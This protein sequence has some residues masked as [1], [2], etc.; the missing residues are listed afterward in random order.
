MLL[1]YEK[2]GHNFA[3]VMTTELSWHVQI[4]DLIESLESW[5]VQREFMEDFN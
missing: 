1:L 5:L 2:T 4:N 3:H